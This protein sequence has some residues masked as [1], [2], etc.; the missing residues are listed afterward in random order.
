MSWNAG[1][2]RRFGGAAVQAAARAQAKG[3]TIIEMRVTSSEISQRTTTR[4]RSVDIAG[5]PCL[6]CESPGTAAVA[7]PCRTGAWSLPAVAM[8]LVLM[9]PPPPALWKSSILQRRCGPSCHRC[10][11]GDHSLAR[12]LSTAH[13]SSSPA[14][15]AMT[16]SPLEARRR[17]SYAMIGLVS[18]TTTTP[19]RLRCL[20][21]LLGLARTLSGRVA[22]ACPRKFAG[23]SWWQSPPLFCLLR[24]VG[25]LLP[26]DLA[27]ITEAAAVPPVGLA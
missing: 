12:A 27:P 10:V 15:S 5:M 20:R 26:P 21:R 7:S 3:R 19:P 8:A 22:R 18:L 4:T 6:R 9:L 16:G 14:A 2:G 25:T 24:Q 17:W 11:W 23:F 13:S 1:F